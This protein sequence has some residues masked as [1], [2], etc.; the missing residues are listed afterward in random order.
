MMAIIKRAVIVI[1][2]FSATPAVCQAEGESA[3]GDQEYTFNS[4]FLVG[5]SSQTDLK[6]FDTTTLQP[7]TYSVDVYNNG[8]WKGLHDLTITKDEKGRAGV[9]YTRDMLNDFGLDVVKLNKDKSA[10]VNFCGRLSEWNSEPALQDAFSSAQLRLDISVPQ[11]YENEQFRGYVAPALWDK[12]ISALNIA[13]MADYYDILQSDNGDKGRNAYLGLQA[14][15]SS[16]G[17]QLHHNGNANWTDKNGAKWTSNETT[18]TRPLPPIKSLLTL[19]QFGSSGDSFDSVNLL[20]ASLA[21]DNMMYPDNMIT[22]APVINGVAETNALVTVYQNNNLIYQSS[23]APG[24]FS[25]NNVYPSGTGNDLIVTVHEADG[26]EKTFSV[27]FNS[28]VK[29][30]HPGMSD[31]SLTVGE[32]NDDSLRNKPTIGVGTWRYG[33][34]NTF[35]VYG[36]VSG[37]NDYQ[38][39]QAGSGMNTSIGGLAVD[40]TQ[41]KTRLANDD[42]TG[43]QYRLTFNRLF[44]AS[45]TGISLQFSQATESYYS[46]PSAIYIIDQQK[47]GIFADYA[48]KKSDLSVTVNQQFPEGWGNIY[49]SGSFSRYWHRPGTEEQYSV[50]YGN[51]WGK[52]NWGINLQRVYTNPNRNTASENDPMFGSGLAPA[53]RKKD[54]TISLNFS[55]P[56]SFGEDKTASVSSNSTFKNGSFDSTQLGLNGSLNKENTL[57]YG[58][59]SSANQSNDY[60]VGLNGNYIAPWSSLTASYSYGNTYQQFGAG[61]S[62]TMLVHSGGV[63]LSSEMGPTL[64]LAE[65][66]GAKGAAIAGSTSRF[67]SNGYALTSALQPYRVNNIEVDMKGASEDVNFDSTNLQIAPYEGSVTKVVFKT[68]VTKS[69]ML[70]AHRPG[71]IALPFGAEITDETGEPI[72]F[73]GQGSSLFINSD[74]AKKARIGWDGG[75]CEVNLLQPALKEQVCL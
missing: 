43:Q 13:Y 67:D 10:E 29:L 68:K 75:Q 56:L 71:H 55:Y 69:R 66:K 59:T 51:T 41:A 60:D 52:L 21:T 48:P 15:L 63:T 50:G 24:P 16:A 49:L 6:R 18:L 26:R 62:G 70:I 8:E 12:G 30:L 31:Y 7:G 61:A 20:G 45:Q 38:A 57:L 65:A 17:W 54:D 32:A 23:V 35:T 3:G 72:G 28:V 73:V 40:V 46:L 74:T 4:N 39:W 47:K 9:C 36:G 33:L 5:A 2:F 25:L 14:Y 19:G 27:P 1:I 44:A 42:A 64:T 34:N 53:Q 11:Q 58:V 37:F 22:Y